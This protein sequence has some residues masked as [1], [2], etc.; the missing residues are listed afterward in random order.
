MDEFK[1]TAKTAEELLYI[2]K[3]LPANARL[4]TGVI[5][6]SYACT[7]VWYNPETNQITLL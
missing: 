6:V 1:G 7:E 3:Q 4:S 5:D 2:L